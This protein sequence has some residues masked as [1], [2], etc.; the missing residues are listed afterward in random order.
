MVAYV[1]T[2]HGRLVAVEIPAELD[3]DE[4]WEDADQAS[5]DYALRDLARR[6]RA[7]ARDIR[8]DAAIGAV[9]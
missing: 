5:L 4:A 8:L 7:W 2:L 9:E 3:P 6:R 1:I